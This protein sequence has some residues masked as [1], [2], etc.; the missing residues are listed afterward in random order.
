MK[1]IYDVD[2]TIKV[3]VPEDHNCKVMYKK[4]LFAGNW[5]LAKIGC[6]FDTEEDKFHGNYGTYG[7][8]TFYGQD[9]VNWNSKIEKVDYDIDFGY[10]TDEF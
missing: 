2:D 6:V 9:Y 8:Y 4:H 1:P 5:I 10:N 7:V 3:F